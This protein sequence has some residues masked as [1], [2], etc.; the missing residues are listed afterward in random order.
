MYLKIVLL[1]SFLV[2]MFG[3]VLP[4]LFSYPST[5]LV[6]LGWGIVPIIPYIGYKVIINI[7]KDFSKLNQKEN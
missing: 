3:F 1:I 6:L 7:L 2:G 4:F 5:E